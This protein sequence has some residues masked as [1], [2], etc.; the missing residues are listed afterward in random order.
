MKRLKPQ[1]LFGCIL[2]CG[3]CSNLLAVADNDTNDSWK[4]ERAELGKALTRILP[5]GWAI[6]DRISSLEIIGQEIR[7]VW[8]ISLPNEPKDVIW[9]DFSRPM[10]VHISIRFQASVTDVDLAEMRK[11]RDRFSELTSSAAKQNRKGWGDSIKDYGY[12]RLPDFQSEAVAVFVDNNTRGYWIRPE[13][14]SSVIINI[15][16]ELATRFPRVPGK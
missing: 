10:K 1:F 12:I 8:P 11:I 3:L 15:S 14:A 16:K 6:E 4:A 2:L 9:R 7:A 13:E 5:A